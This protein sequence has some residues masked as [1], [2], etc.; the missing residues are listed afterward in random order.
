VV[1]LLAVELLEELPRSERQDMLEVLVLKEFEAVLMVR[2][3]EEL[4]MDQSF[5]EIGFT[6]LSLTDVKQRLENLLNRKISTNVLF[7]RP[8]VDALL[9]HL[10]QDVVVELFDSPSAR[11]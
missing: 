10:M 11:R 8:T 3:G 4:P 1:A 6:S 7:N 2:D 9:D 5:F